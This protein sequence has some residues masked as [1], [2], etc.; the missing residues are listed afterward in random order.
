MHLSHLLILIVI[1]VVLLLYL[2]LDFITQLD[3]LVHFGIIFIVS[4]NLGLWIFRY[5]ISILVFIISFC[6]FCLLFILLF[7]RKTHHFRKYH[8]I[9]QLSLFSPP[10]FT[11]RQKY[12]LLSNL[13]IFPTLRVPQQIFFTTFI[14]YL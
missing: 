14:S 3:I 9:F 7:D 13:Q 11:S 10:S 12:S 6:L 2:F 4:R 8:P 1:Y 5:F